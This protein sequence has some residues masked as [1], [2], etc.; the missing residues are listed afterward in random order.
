M[1]IYLASLFLAAPAAYSSVDFLH[2][3]CLQY[4]LP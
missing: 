2:S 4:L 3:D 1:K